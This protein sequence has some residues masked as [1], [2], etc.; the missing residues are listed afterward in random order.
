DAYNQG[1][2]ERRAAAVR[3]Y[4]VG[5]HQVDPSK[6]KAVGKGKRELLSDYAPSADIQRRVR[7]VNDG[8][9]AG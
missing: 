1:L 4:L 5:Q 2:S 9:G 8:G 6:L 3:S 7:I